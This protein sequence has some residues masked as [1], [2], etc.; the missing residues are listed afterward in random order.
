MW[1]S[2]S[3]KQ[4]FWLKLGGIIRLYARYLHTKFRRILSSSLR[5]RVSEYTWCSRIDNLL[6]IINLKWSDLIGASN[7]PAAP[8]F[9]YTVSPDPLFR[10]GRRETR[11]SL[12][13]GMGT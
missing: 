7:I 10:V 3:I 11:V 12:K 13:G 4:A 5:E 2:T 8:N 6:Y 9:L 1:S